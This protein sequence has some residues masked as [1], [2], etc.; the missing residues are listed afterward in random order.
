MPKH[1]TDDSF[2]ADVINSATPVIVDFW[3]QWCGPCLQ[4]A[5]TL[6]E[7]ADE[8]AGRVTV[9]KL[10]VDDNPSTPSKYG[11]RAI[12]TLMIFKDGQV[13]DTKTGALAKSRLVEW[14]ESVL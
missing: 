4:I 12:P 10:N 2:E 6:E 1:V 5:P 3:A 8:M 7:I 11:I 9:A 14:V 13:A